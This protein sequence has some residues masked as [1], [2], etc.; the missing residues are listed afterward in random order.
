VEL[1]VES[2]NRSVAGLY[3]TF[4]VHICFSDYSL[5]FPYVEQLENCSQF[6]L[7]FANRDPRTLGSDKA[8]RPAYEILQDFHKHTPDIGIGLGVTS[9]HDNN[10]E[11]VN[12]VRDRVL[13]AVDIVGD[14][15]LIY[16]S[17]DCGLRTR[18]WDIAFDKLRVTAEGTELA[19]QAL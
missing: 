19:K 12:L 3:G 15:S 6:S 17:P 5:L 13:R 14:P 8:S 11:G 4:S 1:F 7:E 18:S 2:F 9:V 16:P 10:V